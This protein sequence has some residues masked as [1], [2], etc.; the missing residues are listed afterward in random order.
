[1]ARSTPWWK[2]LQ[3]PRD[4]RAATLFATLLLIGDA[5]LSYIIIARVPYT[6]IDWIAYMQE[7]SGFVKGERN[8]EELKGDTGPLVYPAGFVYLFTALQALT[9][10]SIAAAQAIFAGVYL[11]TQA[12]VMALY[13]RSRALPPWTLCLLCLSRR[14]HSIFLLRLFNDC[15]AMLLAYAATLLL[16]SR[17]WTLAIFVY[18]AAVSVKMNVLLWAPGVLAVLIRLASPLPVLRGLAAGLLLQAL[19]AGPFLAVAPRAYLGR[20]F[21]LTRVFQQRWSVNWQFVPADWFVDRRFAL[22]L[23]A[24]HLRLLWSFARFRWFQA[25]GGV[26]PALRRFFSRTTKEEAE[27]SPMSLDFMLYILFTANLAGILSARSL[28]YQF[29]SWYF[30]MLPYLLLRTR[31][32]KSLSIGLLLCIEGVWNIYPP[33]AATSAVF[34]FLHWLLAAACWSLP[35]PLPGPATKVLG[36]RP[37]HRRR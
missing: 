2:R 27:A 1:M 21:E 10:G 3:D 11:L 18:S 32:P 28:H 17:R 19:L 30:H 16:Q 23:L 33:H 9:G 25:E 37:V 6:E 34:Q 20:A 13:I 7:V 4:V 24:L 8:Y 29:Y 36:R 12:A 14:V 35:A 26:G 15:W 5:L 31:L 22:V